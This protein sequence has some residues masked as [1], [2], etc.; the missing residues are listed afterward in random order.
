MKKLRCLLSGRADNQTNIMIKQIL[1]DNKFEVH[2]MDSNWEKIKGLNSEIL[3]FSESSNNSDQLE[4]IK[5]G[6][7]D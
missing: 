7:Q 3:F 5:K 2:Y 6:Y 1:L 4:E